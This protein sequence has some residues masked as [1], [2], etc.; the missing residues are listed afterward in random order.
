VGGETRW[1]RSHYENYF[2]TVRAR[3]STAALVTGRQLL[4]AP[5]VQSYM[6]VSDRLRVDFGAR[7]DVLA[8]R[9]APQGDA[10]SS[11]THG[12]LS[13]KLGAFVHLTPE[14]G[15]YANVSR[16][17]RSSDGIIIDPT[18]E[19]IVVWA[20]ETGLKVDRAGA[21]ASASLFR[22]NVSNE[23]TFNPITLESSNG[24]AS[25]RQGVE[26]DWRVPVVARVA[27]VWGDWTFNDA[28]Y[29][30]LVAVSEDGDE[31]PAVLNGLR[32]YNTS[33]YVGNAAVDLT[34][35]GAPWRVRL[36]GNWVGDYSPFDEPGVVIGGY[37][38]AHASATWTFGAVDADVGVRNVFDRA[39]AE[40]VAGH[41]VS[42]GQPRTVFVSLRARR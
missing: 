4:G 5:F 7:Y 28:R 25:R 38:L 21:S 37:G 16:G 22:M 19:P 13:P 29:K 24:G 20:Y 17:F 6:D 14:V 34:R 15:A 8:T 23:Q 42:P 9:S 31:P 10:S 33:K 12:V 1:D 30:S 39:Y 18:L 11:A 3:D 26:L 41:I 32:V 2:T 40:V 35:P 27:S 36:S